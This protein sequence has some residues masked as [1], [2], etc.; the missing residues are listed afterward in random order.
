MG[1]A[2]GRLARLGPALAIE[3]RIWAPPLDRLVIRSTSP[4][5]IGLK[6]TNGRGYERERLRL[7][8]LA[9]ADRGRRGINGHLVRRGVRERPFRIGREDQNRR[10]HQLNVPG[11]AG[12]MRTNGAETGSG[13]RPSVTIGS[14][15]TIRISLACARLSRHPTRDITTL[16]STWTGGLIDWTPARPECISAGLK[17]RRYVPTRDRPLRTNNSIGSTR[18]AV[19]M[20]GCCR[21]LS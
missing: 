2:G 8:K 16:N 9:T 12:L 3:P 21:Y 15:N 1:S 10:T 5:P 6:Q 11:T 13:I 14:E 19:R 20:P 7:C 18:P 4:I 17:P